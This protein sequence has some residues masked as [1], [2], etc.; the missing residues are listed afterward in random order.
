MGQEPRIPGPE[1]KVAPI[2]MVEEE[3]GPEVWV[4]LAD[5]LG[6]DGE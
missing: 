2:R 3:F 4:G 1:E 5:L 6:A